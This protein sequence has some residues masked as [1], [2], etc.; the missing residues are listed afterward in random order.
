MHVGCGDVDI[1]SIAFRESARLPG[2]TE[3][4]ITPSL[5]LHSLL[6]CSLQLRTAPHPQLL[7]LQLKLL[8]PPTTTPASSAGLSSPAA[9]GLELLLPW[10]WQ[11]KAGTP[12]NG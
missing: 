11:N 10:G 1:Q 2:K 12:E 3:A 5:M 6:T 8:L 4:P 7:P 9:S